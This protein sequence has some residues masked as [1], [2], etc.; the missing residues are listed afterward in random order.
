MTNLSNTIFEKRTPDQSTWK[1]RRRKSE[2]DKNSFAEFVAE[3]K[4]SEHGR[5]HLKRH[6]GGHGL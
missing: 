3:A 6:H 2:Q 1:G 4:R 5:D